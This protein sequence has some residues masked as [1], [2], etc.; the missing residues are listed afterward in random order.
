MG[1]LSDILGDGANQL[2]EFLG[3][4]VP[5]VM[6]MGSVPQDNPNVLATIANRNP[7][8]S[9]PQPQEAPKKPRRSTLE[10]LGGIADALAMAGG[11]APGYREGIAFR[12]Q[13]DRELQNQEWANKLNQQKL[14]AGNSE[15]ANQRLD[16]FGQAA[17]G[18]GVVMERSGLPGVQKAIPLIAQQMGLSPEEQQI[19]ASGFADDPEGTIAM[20]QAA[21]APNSPVSQPKEV[22]IYNMLKKQNPEAAEK[23][24][25][26]VASG[27]DEYERARI[28]VQ[29]EGIHSRERTTRD[30]NRTRIVV[31]RTKS[32]ATPA[33]TAAAEQARVGAA[34]AAKQIVA[35]MRDAYGRLRQAGGINAAGQSAAQRVGAIANANIPFVERV[36]NPEGFSAREDL[37]RLRTVGISS[38]LP[39][40]GSL[41]LGS[42][43]I[44]AAK[45]LETWSKAIASAD[46]Y[47]SA[48]R[49]LDGIQ[50]RIDEITSAP[51][52]SSGARPR[53]RLTPKNAPKAGSR[54]KYNPATGRIE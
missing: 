46:D 44:D 21:T 6:G 49:A 13:R 47:E 33:K 14:E 17:R 18:L 36:S 51:P 31:A 27:Y 52:A 19:F 54:F 16:R 12:E 11:S 53:I 1:F 35:D 24:L 7:L 5:R 30:T 43:N 9:A 38:L 4:N 39:I 20:L 29:T 25:Q 32:N 26:T 48:M 8:P 41:N 2:Q 23:Y 3:Q 22:T 37:E 40:L 15:L 45:E 34:N 42:R 10:V 28:G 50:K